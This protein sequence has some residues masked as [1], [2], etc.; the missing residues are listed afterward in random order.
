[1]PGRTLAP[2]A[3]VIRELPL[4][5]AGIGFVPKVTVTPA[6]CPEADNVMALLK[7]FN[8]VVVMVEVPL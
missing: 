7:P 2:T 4:P 6:G 8:A 5:G 1:V 3:I